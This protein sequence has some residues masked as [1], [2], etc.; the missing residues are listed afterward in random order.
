MKRALL[1]VALVGCD[2]PFFGYTATDAGPVRA[3]PDYAFDVRETSNLQP[4]LDCAPRVEVTATETR[5]E[6]EVELVCED[7][8]ITFAVAFDDDALTIEEGACTLEGDEVV[9]GRLRMRAAERRPLG[10]AQARAIGWRPHDTY[11]QS[12]T[13]PALNYPNIARRGYY[14]ELIALG[15]RLVT[16]RNDVENVIPL[17]PGPTATWIEDPEDDARRVPGPPCL[18]TGVAL[19]GRSFLAAYGEDATYFGRFVAENAGFGFTITASVAFDPLA[20]CGRRVPEPT[21]DTRVHHVVRQIRVDPAR[22][23]A[24]V[25]IFESRGWLIPDAPGPAEAFG[26]YLLIVDLASLEI[27]SCRFFED[28][29]AP[30]FVDAHFAD[31]FVYAIDDPNNF[32]HRYDETV[33]DSQGTIDFSIGLARY[34]AEMT[35]DGDRAFVADASGEILI[36]DLERLRHNGGAAPFG[37]ARTMRPTTLTRVGDLYAVGLYETVEDME[38]GAVGDAWIAWFDPEREMFLPDATRLTIP[39]APGVPTGMIGRLR[40]VDGGARLYALLSWTGA[41]AEL[42]PAP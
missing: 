11:F 4:R 25:A 16:F 17:C 8:T 30:V 40:V 19:D 15:D 28:S 34:I 14:Q 5:C 20:D 29:R 26:S 41:V 1:L 6:V 39:D 10:Y 24:I 21:M 23:R 2:S 42:V 37:V 32:L 36:G 7:E 12:T 31:R 18:S 13:Q 35:F 33:T 38:R 27:R 9:C 3:C 22:A